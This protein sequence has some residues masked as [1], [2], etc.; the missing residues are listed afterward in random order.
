MDSKLIFTSFE[1]AIL[2]LI[3]MSSIKLVAETY[4]DLDNHSI[5]SKT[6]TWVDRLFTVVFTLEAV[7]KM[8]RSGFLVA[9]SSYLRDSWSIL[10]FTIVVTSLLDLSVES[11]GLPFLRILR[12]LRI[13]RPLRF[14]SQNQNL[15]IVVNALVE[16]IV[17]ILN[18]LIVIGM[19]WVMF[20]ILGGN[21]M[22]GKLG[23]CKVDIDHFDFYGVSRGD[24][25]SKYEGVW[26]D[27]DSNFEN[28]FNGM[29]TLFVLSTLEGWPTTLG[30]ALDANDPD[31]GPIRNGSP[32]NGLFF[33]VF[34]L[35]G[36]CMII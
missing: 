4:L 10:D 11:V 3:V 22:R 12:L 17:A 13:L 20:S 34:I 31:S 29:V 32:L 36:N 15:R 18:V 7:M 26:T 35:V 6:F 23:Y 24:C 14:I 1:T 5:L 2:S 33:I 25:S 9:E 30:T 28:I 27:Y 19:I 16:S 21:L 8:M